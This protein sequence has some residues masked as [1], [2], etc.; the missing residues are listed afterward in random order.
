[1]EKLAVVADAILND[2]ELAK[3][4]DPT[5]KI[6]TKWTVRNWRLTGGMPYFNAGKRIFFRLE[7]VLAWID[8]REKGGFQEEQFQ[9]GKIRRID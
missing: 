3:A 6:V 5:G 2:R 7:S 9:Y 4:L 8:Q 1:M